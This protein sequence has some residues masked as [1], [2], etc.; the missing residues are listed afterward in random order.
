MPAARGTDPGGGCARVAWVRARARGVGAGVG[1]GVGG[2]GRGRGRWCGSSVS[3]ARSGLFGLSRVEAAGAG[4][5]PEPLKRGGRA[6]PAAADALF[7][8]ALCRP[9]GE[10]AVGVALA[11]LAQLARLARLVAPPAP[12][13]PPGRVWKK[14]RRGPSAENGLFPENG[15]LCVVGKNVRFSRAEGARLAP[16]SWRPPA[17]PRAARPRQAA[18]TKTCCA[19]ETKAAAP[20]RPSKRTPPARVGCAARS[21]HCPTTSGPLDPETDVFR[22][23]A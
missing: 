17:R 21:G 13:A 9:F 3:R 6:A 16:M 18:G 10:L 4:G 12:P 14:A 1:V 7:P 22:K 15:L 5:R 23:T 8:D 19:R 11:R 20:A 2:R